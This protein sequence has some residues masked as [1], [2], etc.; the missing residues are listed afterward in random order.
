MPHI[1]IEAIVAIAGLVVTLPPSAV[2]LWRIVKSNRNVAMD[3][4]VW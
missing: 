1:S 3:I 2:I 4:E